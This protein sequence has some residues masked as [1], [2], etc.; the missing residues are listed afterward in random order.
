MGLSWDEP[1]QAPSATGRGDS[2]APPPALM[3]NWCRTASTN[4]RLGQVLWDTSPRRERPVVLHRPTSARRCEHPLDRSDPKR[5]RF[6]LL[7]AGP[8]GAAVGRGTV[9]LVDPMRAPLSTET[10][11]LREVLAAEHAAVWGYGAVGAALP[12]D[13]REP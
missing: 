13:G 7:A 8:A 9:D 2:S 4:R 5:R 10:A 1:A 6:L 12:E 11:A 3:E